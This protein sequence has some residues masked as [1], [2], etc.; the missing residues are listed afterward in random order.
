MSTPLFAQLQKG[1]SELAAEILSYI[2]RW[3]HDHQTDAGFALIKE[4]IRSVCRL[5]PAMPSIGL[6]RRSVHSL[7]QQPSSIQLHVALYLLSG[8]GSASNVTELLASELPDLVGTFLALASLT[9]PRSALA[10]ASSLSHLNVCKWESLYVISRTTAFKLALQK[11][12][13]KSVC[14]RVD[15]N[16]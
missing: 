4:F 13:A 14:F 9:F 7:Q 11:Y 2:E 5:V 12:S 10:D 16:K 15:V 3:A 6:I 1:M 8:I